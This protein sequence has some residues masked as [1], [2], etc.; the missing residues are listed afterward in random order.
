MFSPAYAAARR[1]GDADPE[2]YCGLNVAIYGPGADAWAFSEYGR[3]RCR[4]SADA[5]ELGESALRWQDGALVIDLRERTAPWGRPLV[6][7]VRVRPDVMVDHRNALD[8]NGRHTWCAVA[9]CGVADVELERPALAFAGSAYHDANFGDESLEA[10]FS[11]W[12]WARADVPGGTAV[13]YDVEPRRGPPSTRGWIF[14][15]D[16][17]TADLAAPRQ[18]ALPTTGW[19]VAR[20][21]RSDGV[22]E[23]TLR[24]TLEDTP[25]Y[26]RSLVDLS[27]AG[28]PTTA[29]HEALDL[30]R[31]SSR[32]VQL[33]LRFRLRRRG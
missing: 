21:V 27:L 20:T 23:V 14:S 29:I 15:P 33:L 26:A 28:T 13:L 4:R 2:E 30:D 6:G 8:C 18:V 16:G 25:F 1:R 24:R 12:S 11:R 32:L 19:G 3:R 9:P 7:R 10:G 22:G 31:F 5:L 17:S